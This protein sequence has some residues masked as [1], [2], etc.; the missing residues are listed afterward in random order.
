MR[1]HNMIRLYNKRYHHTRRST[2]GRSGSTSP[3]QGKSKRKRKRK[4]PGQG[5]DANANA[6]AT[7]CEQVASRWKIKERTPYTS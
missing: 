5:Q 7:M 4:G 1:Q 6:K 3:G 2:R